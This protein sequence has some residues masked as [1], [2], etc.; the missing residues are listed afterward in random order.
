M[1][2]KIS[3]WFLH[4]IYLN[5]HC[6]YNITNIIL[7]SSNDGSLE[8]K[9]ECRLCF[10]LRL[11]FYLDYL[12]INFSRSLSLSIY[13]YI[14]KHQ[15]RLAYGSY[16]TPPP[17]SLSF[18]RH[19]SLL[20]DSSP[21]LFLL[22]FVP[23]IWLLSLSLSLVIR[24]YSLTPLSLSFSCHSSLLSDSSP[25]LFLLSFVPIIW[26]LSLSLS[27]V[28]RPYYLTP[29]LCLSLSLAIRPYYIISSSSY[30]SLSLSLSLSLSGY[31]F[32]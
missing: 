2:Y 8:T 19:S 17:P 5:I 32:L 7:L 25:S 11:S 22:S 30:C 21:S 14:Y 24:P 27:L 20:S 23:I 13:I 3:Q 10:S 12:V 9:L 18:S 15:V 6:W 4:Y 28:I 31:S 16:L 29:P 1:I 26:L